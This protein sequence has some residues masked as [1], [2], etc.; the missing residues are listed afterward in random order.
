[1]RSRR[2]VGIQRVGM[3]FSCFLRPPTLPGP[4]SGTY[5]T[6]NPYCKAI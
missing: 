4:A 2:G 1:V 6:G 5:G 3:I